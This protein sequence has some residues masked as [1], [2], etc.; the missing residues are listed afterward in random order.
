M[1]K[2]MKPDVSEAIFLYELIEITDRAAHGG[3]V[4]SFGCVTAAP[5]ISDIFSFLHSIGVKMKSDQVQ[6]RNR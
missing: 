3:K 2:I 4:I 5:R 6:L 1:P